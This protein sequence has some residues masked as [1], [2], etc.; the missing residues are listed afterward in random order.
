MQGHQVHPAENQAED[1]GERETRQK[2]K[3]LMIVTVKMKI[4]CLFQWL[5][6]MHN[7]H[8][9]WTS[10]TLCSSVWFPSPLHLWLS[11]LLGGLG[12]HL[13]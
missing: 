4:I 3:E 12:V 7:A 11:F 6:I 8:D 10:S 9:H 5:W 2:N 13:A 1:K